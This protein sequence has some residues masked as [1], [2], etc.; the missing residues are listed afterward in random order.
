MIF[1]LLVHSPPV[2]RPASRSAYQ[3]ARTAI[4]AG[5]SVYRVFFIGDGVLH[6]TPLNQPAGNEADL[7]A[8]WREL[9]AAHRVDLALCISSA[10]RRG[11]LDSA[12]A[13]RRRLPASNLR[14]GFAIAGLGQLVDATL[15]SDRVVSF[16]D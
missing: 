7:P 11:V 12:E 15:K 6:G 3:F 4:D 10:L 14:E 9:A 1:S 16:G 8:L 5:H 2:A 13:T